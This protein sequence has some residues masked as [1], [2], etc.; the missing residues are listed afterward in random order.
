MLLIGFMLKKIEAVRDLDMA[1]RDLDSQIAEKLFTHR[2]RSLQNSLPHS[3][4][5]EKYPELVVKCLKNT[6]TI[7]HLPLPE[8]E[9]ICVINL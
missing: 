6:S 4:R 2:N 7:I 9:I 1:A 3:V 5:G 8:Q